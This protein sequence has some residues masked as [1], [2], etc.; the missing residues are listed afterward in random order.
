[1]AGTQL[2][3]H[4]R[5][6]SR[7]SHPLTS[8]RAFARMQSTEDGQDSFSNCPQLAGRALAVPSKYLQS[9][10]RLAFE[11]FEARST[12]RRNVTKLIVIEAQCT[13]RCCGVTSANYPKTISFS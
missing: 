1:M 8:R 3:R 9:G 7:G 6:R 4:H 2:L 11:K 10:Q 12:T 13:N 5:H